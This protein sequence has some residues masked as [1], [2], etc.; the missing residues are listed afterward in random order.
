M[1]TI[2]KHRRKGAL[3][4]QILIRLEEYN[5]LHGHPDEVDPEVFSAW[6]VSEGYFRQPIPTLQQLCKRAVSRALR[7]DRY[8][9]PQGRDVRTHHPLRMPDGKTLWYDI[10][11]ARPEPMRVT[12]QLRRRGVSF[13]CQQLSLDFDSY[14]DNNPHGAKLPALDFDF[15]SDVEEMAQSTEYPD[16]APDQEG[17]PNK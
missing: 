3:E 9:D 14:N 15:T 1:A 10:R 5:R 13:D 6:M 4:K 11:T 12:F 16:E 2:R 7:N 8:I 17:E